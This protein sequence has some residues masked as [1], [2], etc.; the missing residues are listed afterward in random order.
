M[1]NSEDM[2]LLGTR[3]YAPGTDAK[4]G[5]IIS[6]LTL[7]LMEEWQCVDSIV[8]MV[9][10]TTASHTG[11]LSAACVA[12]QNKLDRPL[13]WSAC[14]HH[15]GE[16]IL[17][18]VFADI[19]IEVSKSPDV[20]IFSKFRK[21]YEEIQTGSNKHLCRLDKSSYTEEAAAIIKDLEENSIKVLY[22]KYDFARDDYK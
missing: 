10:D 22:A 3:S 15:I 19:K 4:S 12:I 21:H 13:L 18:H 9:F 7:D 8:N 11:H 6:S 20:V 16:V 2:K 1:G 5:D 14:R 17:S